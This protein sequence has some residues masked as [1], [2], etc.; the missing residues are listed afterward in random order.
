[1]SRKVTA[2]RL[3]LPIFVLLL[4]AMALAAPSVVNVTATLD[5]LGGSPGNQVYRFNYSVENLDVQPALAGFIVFFDSDGL[6]R[7]DFVEYTYPAGWEDI[8]VFPEGPDGA[9]NVEWDEIFGTNRILPGGTLDGFSVT[10]TWNDPT[11][12]PGPQHF[13]AWN[14]EAHDGYTV[15]IPGSSL[16]GSIQGNVVTVCG[17]N[18]TPTAGITVDLYSFDNVLLD[19]TTTDANGFYSFPALQPGPYKVTIVTPTGFTADQ[20]TKTASVAMGDPTVVDFGLTCLP[21]TPSQ[22]T[23]GYWKHQVN[24]Y[25]TGKGKAQESLSELTAYMEEIRIHFNENLLNPIKIF[26]VVDPDGE[27][28]DSL[29]VLQRLL[30]VNK[31]GTMLDRA[32]QQMIALLLNVIS[33]KLSQAEVISEDGANVS[34]AITYCS[35]LIEDHDTSNDEL[36]KDICDY[37]NNGLI[38]PAGWIPTGTVIIYYEKDRPGALADARC[39][40]NPFSGST[41]ISFALKGASS[42]PVQLKVFDVTGRVVRTLI[43]RSVE[44]GQHAVAWDGISDAGVRASSGVYFYEL[45]VPGFVSSGKLVIRR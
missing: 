34:Q 8:F 37:I 32:K 43:D 7:S 25:L 41:R 9:W 10:F 17:G 22:R 39:Y 20:E 42:Q 4:P 18:T 14:G 38:V 23:I 35:S 2:M 15:V 33:L 3:A 36:A 40:P 44:P 26:M 13:E 27:T 30:T 24:V 28:V 16:L 1:M 21:I 11:S 31:D 6:G 5:F 29:A 45:S 19:V 12:L